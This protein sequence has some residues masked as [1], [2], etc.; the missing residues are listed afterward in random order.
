MDVVAKNEL[1]FQFLWHSSRKVKV[2]AEHEAVTNEN[3]EDEGRKHPCDSSTAEGSEKQPQ[4]TPKIDQSMNKH[5]P[6]AV[7]HFLSCSS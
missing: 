4:K 7:V 3:L 2:V 6:P 5:I 1:S